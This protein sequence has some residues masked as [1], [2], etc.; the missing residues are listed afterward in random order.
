MFYVYSADKTLLQVL[1][2]YASEG[3]VEVVQNWGEGLPRQN[4]PHYGQS[5]SINECSYRNM[6]RVK[7][8]VYTDLDEFIVPRKSI[9]WKDMMNQIDNEKYGTFV[10]RNF[11]S[12]VL[13]KLE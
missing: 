8:L 3:T 2:E 7:Y 11:S 5:L 1:H 10:F 6:Y 12:K 4:I 9:G 13:K